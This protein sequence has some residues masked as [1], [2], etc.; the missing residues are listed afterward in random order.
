MEFE[1]KIELNKPNLNGRIYTTELWQ[2]VLK[3]YQKLIDEKRALGRVGYGQSAALDL[4]EVMFLVK[5]AK[6]EDN[7]LKVKIETINNIKYGFNHAEAFIE[8][9]KAAIRPVGIAEI[10][11]DGKVYNYK[12]LYFAIVPKEDA[13]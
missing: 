2:E 7:F 13:A 1:D 3:D 11:K 12:L 10:G 5:E 4:G 8:A 9:K 6:I